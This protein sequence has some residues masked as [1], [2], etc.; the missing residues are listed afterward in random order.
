MAKK[1]LTAV[2]KV[3]GKE[4]AP[5]EVSFPFN[6][7]DSDG[8]LEIEASQEFTMSHQVLDGFW[9]GSRAT[10]SIRTRCSKEQFVVAQDELSTEALACAAE[11]VKTSMLY[12]HA[13]SVELRNKLMESENARRGK[14]PFVS[15]RD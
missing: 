1:Q 7:L 10:C 9:V 15:R 8:E 13:D 4:S 5:A 6:E 11:A 14:S 3:R 2:V 12:W